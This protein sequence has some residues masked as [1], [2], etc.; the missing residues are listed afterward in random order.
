MLVETLAPTSP[1]GGFWKHTQFCF[2][3]LSWNNSYLG[4]VQTVSIA[5]ILV[6]ILSI[7]VKVCKILSL[8]SRVSELVEWHTLLCCLISAKIHISAYVHSRLLAHVSFA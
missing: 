7:L 3:L 8:V 1:F 5:T 4:E 6:K 2:K